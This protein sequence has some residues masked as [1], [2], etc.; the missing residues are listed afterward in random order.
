MT[1]ETLPEKRKYEHYAR[2]EARFDS[3]VEVME[4]RLNRFFVRA[5]AAFAI[6]GL[7]S[8]GSLLGFSAVL[9]E[10]SKTSTEIQTQ[11]FTTLLQS[12]RDQNDRN[13]D[14]KKQIDNAIDKLPKK[15]REAAEERSK[16]FRLIM[17]A[18]APYR[19]DCR[20]YANARVRGDL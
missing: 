3:H 16:S 11:R 2:L 20:A 15:E 17:D 10:Q 14:V 9:S 12:C 8:A 18:A 19:S 6:L 1:E 7:T 5:L 13:R 4:A